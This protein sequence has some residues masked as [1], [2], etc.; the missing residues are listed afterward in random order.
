MNRNLETEPFVDLNFS[1]EKAVVI[2]AT[3]RSGSTL[4]CQYIQSLKMG[5]PCEYFVE[6]LR[7]SCSS[8]ELVKLGNSNN[9]EYYSIKLMSDYLQDFGWWVSKARS[10]GPGEAPLKYATEGLKYLEGKFSSIVWIKLKR[11]SIFEQASSRYLSEKTN[12]WHSWPD[13]VSD[14]S[15]RL[16]T[17]TTKEKA[18]LEAVKNFD[19]SSFLEHCKKVIDQNLLLDEVVRAARIK[20]VIM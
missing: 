19:L 13:G 8:K 11:S 12:L 6:V 20:C 4:L 9:D 5:S 7:G 2:L 1:E 10:F 14:G 3:Q 16:V 18:H 15:D 17:I